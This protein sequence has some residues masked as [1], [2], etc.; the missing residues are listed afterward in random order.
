MPA[1]KPEANRRRA[2]KIVTVKNPGAEEQ[3]GLDQPPC[4]R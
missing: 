3:Y 4:R 1:K 2:E